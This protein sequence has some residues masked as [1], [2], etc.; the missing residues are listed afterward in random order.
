VTEC[1]V[2][3]A[4]NPEGFRFCGACGAS[5][6]T[7][8]RASEER[9]VVTTLFCDLVDFTSLGEA[10]DPEDVAALLRRYH[11]EA[12]RVIRSHGGT[13]EKFIGDA[14]VGVFGVPVT[15]EDDAERGVR[16]GLR[17][18]QAVRDAGLTRPSGAPV[19]L[20]VGVATGE[21][22]VR[23][24]VEPTSGC[25]FLTGDAVNTAARLQ[26]AAPPM[27]VVAGALT[28]ELTHDAIDYEALPPIRAK[29][30]A[31]PVVVWRARRAR[32]HTG[33]RTSS[34]P[35]LPFLGRDEELHVLGREL[36]VAAEERS[37]RFVLIVGEPGI[38]K[39][40]L[41][42]EFARSLYAR[43]QLTTW[44]MGRC[45]PYGDGVAFWALGDIVKAHA[46]ILDSDD[47]DTVEA[48]LE[49]ALAGVEDAPWLRR[50]LRPLLGLE[51]PRAERSENFTAWARFLELI[52]SARP[53]VVVLEDLH[54]AGDGMLAFLHHLFT[55]EIEA[56]LLVVAT[57]RPEVLE[58]QAGALVTVDGRVRRLT[59]PALSSRHAHSLVTCLLDAGSPVDIREQVVAA[60]GGNPLYAEQYARLLL[61]R[62]FSGGT[63]EDVAP[64]PP[65]EG[66]PLPETLHAV[67]S[68]RIDTVPPDQKALLADAA[69]L[70][71]TF[72]RGGVSAL[73]GR[74][75]AEVDEVMAALCARDLIRPVAVSSVEDEPEY[76]FWHA[77][78]RDV[79]Y[80]QLPRRARARKH[81]A[82][83]AWVSGRAGAGSDELA[84][85]AAHHATVAL[86][87]ARAVGDEEL[88]ASLLPLAID[89]LRR[90]GERGLRLDV[91]AA[92]RHVELALE[93]A[94]GDPSAQPELL[95]L[96]ARILLLT[97][98]CREA[99]PV[100]D[101]AVEELRS[102]GKLRAAALALCWSADAL[103]YLNEPALHRARAAVELLRD[104]GP[105]PEL[106]EVLGHYALG[107][108]IHDEDPHLV[109]AF[110][111]RAISTSDVLGLPDPVVALSTRGAARI[112][113]GDIG[114][115]EDTRRAEAAAESQGL[116]IERSTTMIN[117][118]SL[119]FLVDGAEAEQAAVQA[120]LTFVASHG[121][122]V[123]S[124][125]FESALTQCAYKL[126]EWDQTL[127]RIEAALP[128][129]VR[130]ED[131]WDLLFMRALQALVL[132]ARGRPEAV[133]SVADWLV[134][135][136]RVSEIGWA[137]G[138]ALM[139]AAVVRT[140]LGETDEAAAL[141]SDC[142]AGPQAT[143]AM[144][145]AVPEAARTMVGADCPDLAARLVRSLET[146]A[147]SRGWPLTRHVLVTC[148]SLLQEAEGDC[149]RAADGFARAAEAWRGFSMPFEEAQALLGQGRCLI[150]LGRGPEAV[151]GLG[152]AAAIFE[153]LGAR[154]ALAEVADLMSAVPRVD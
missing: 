111:D 112:T 145:E 55:R 130:L 114:G 28:H 97:N 91:A 76:L 123:H 53:A 4:G 129:L 40:R 36:R 5:L 43:P 144:L 153:R 52:A 41:V 16:A 46:G 87:L 128:V 49:Q 19:Q 105:S 64:V 34:S 21:A 133:E 132:T 54:W 125:A 100:F 62:G 60:A 74:D 23:L 69:V 79:A 127:V 25:G 89:A 22:L 10:A 44:R 102:A 92:E 88:A 143:A 67:L 17:I 108:T 117:H 104:D 57:A 12:Q 48:K 96:W 148:R 93:L 73:S 152:R 35:G 150:R 101:E 65:G 138:F 95:S 116:G 38:G 24:D 37:A 84:E 142:F 122:A 61:E 58:R 119:T 98:R 136:G 141:L 6:A 66:L 106:V 146:L 137:R 107:L 124:G 15:H 59:L 154:P 103:S 50:R 30:K 134:D 7:A 56:P 86:D 13:V 71:E 26:A 77:L 42:L 139:A 131:E 31:E 72:W 27:G 9:K 78:T 151:R 20:R 29:G 115:W 75:A 39:S 113:L 149:G 8:P 121:L 2:C 140:A 126:G 83:A 147:A 110:A 11:A 90:S 68:A 120:G 18:I 94:G 70:G 82:A 80:A 85:I 33:L 118:S 51:A 109:I 32:A 45:L 14:V 3:G 63:G 1:A 81:A 47:A 135:R 99:V